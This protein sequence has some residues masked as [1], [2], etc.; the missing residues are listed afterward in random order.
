MATTM[1]WMTMEEA[2]R[3]KVQT[4]RTGTV[5]T[6]RR[7]A[8]EATRL[9]MGKTQ[10]DAPVGCQRLDRAAVRLTRPPRC[11]HGRGNAVEL[12]AAEAD[13]MHRHRQRPI[14]VAAA[15]PQPALRCSV[16]S[17]LIGL[18]A[19]AVQS[20]ESAA[21]LVEVVVAG[22]SGEDVCVPRDTSDV[23]CAEGVCGVWESL[24]PSE[25]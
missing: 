4:T 8:A 1:R 18:V 17:I 7:A 16:V 11:G 10:Q 14:G 9:W 13:D 5:M 2:L 3:T 25:G 24:L 15:V 21:V 6:D 19:V 12:T 22:K 23:R 20:G